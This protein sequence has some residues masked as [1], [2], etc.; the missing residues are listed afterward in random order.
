MSEFSLFD[1]VTLIRQEIRKEQI[2]SVKKITGP[3]GDKGD[4]GEPGG[5]GIQGPKGDKGDRGAAGPKGDSG[6]KGDKG[7]K[8]EDGKD[9]VSITRVEQDIDGAVVVHM[10]DG[11]HYIIELPLV[12]GQAP[13]EVHY[14]VGGG[15]GGSGSGDGG[16]GTIDLSNYVRRPNSN[17][18]DSWL[19]YKEGSD[20]SKKWTPVTTD[21][22]EVNPNPFRN[23]K[24][25][26]IGTP[27]ELENLKTQRDVNEFFYKA[28]GDIEAGDVNLDGYA[29]EVWVTEQIDGIDFPVGTI[30]S[31]TAPADPEDGSTWYDT[32]RLEL[33]VFAMGAWLP[34]S[35]LG[36]R[37]E[38]GEILQAQIL[39]RV[40]AGE[41]QQQTLV[42][43]K[44]GKSEA[45]EVANSFRIKGTGGTYISASGGELGLYH[46]KYPEAETHAATMQYVLDEIAKVPVAEN[47]PTKRY[48]GNRFNV[49]G[50]STK[51]L[52]SGEVMF[53]RDSAT[54]TNLA[55]VNLIGLPEQEF[56]W[57]SC[58][59]SGV[60][61]VKNG[62]QLAAYFNVY[63][64]TRNEG[65]NVLLHVALIQMGPGYEVDYDSGTPCYFHGVFFA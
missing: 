14:K 58:A 15:S 23:A 11:E 5:P 36:A 8:G 65:R 17:Q 64:M 31:D 47:G 63:D 43:T 1:I 51:S 33:F 20:G 50:T 48:D 27:E 30:V 61:K 13:A 41:V 37:V 52:S 59:K 21:L 10:S 24:G 25:Q 6:K 60:V 44:L 46:V 54:T 39:S 7:A 12:Q 3:K 28:I 62:S 29:T 49:S 32:V 19:V 18:Q 16:S 35:P 2:G 55:T 42:D 53:L 56:D 45:N 38:Q 34:C 9:G 40:E 22:V 4:K 26:F 57:D